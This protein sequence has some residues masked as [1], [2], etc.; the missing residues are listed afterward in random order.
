[1]DHIMKPISPPILQARACRPTWR[2]RPRPTLRSKSDYLSA[3]VALAHPGAAAGHSDVTIIAL[4]SLA[5]HR[6][7][8]TGN[9]IRR[10]QLYVAVGATEQLRR[11]P[12]VRAGAHGVDDRPCSKS[13]PLHDIGKVGVPDHILLSRTADCRGSSRAKTHAAPGGARSRVPE[14]R[15]G[16]RAC[17]FLMWPGDNGLPPP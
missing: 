6:D 5:E 4:A 1:M 7:A 2:S 17:G 12:S 15:L 13:A 10:T 14:R 16:M 9:H 8:E 3:R 11:H